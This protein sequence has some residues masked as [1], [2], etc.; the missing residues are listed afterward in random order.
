M[1][2]ALTNSAALPHSE[3]SRF[4]EGFVLCCSLVL[5]VGLAAAFFV[6]H[7]YVLYYGDAQSHLNISRSI[8]D[9]RTP[10]FQ[11]IGNVWLPLLHLICLPF[12]GSD[13][14]WSTGLAGT[15]PVAC[16]F[17][18]TGFCLYWTARRVYHDRRAAAVVVSCF[19]L[20]PNILY[21]SS[22][23]MTEMVFFAGLTLFLLSFVQ[24]RI[25]NQARW[26]FTAI[27]ASWIMSLTRYDGWFLIPFCALWFAIAAHRRRLL[28][29]L[30]VA[31]AASLAPLFWI[32]FNWFETGNALD[33]FNGPYSAKA[34]QGNRPYPGL[35]DWP[36]ALLYY[37]KAGQ[38]CA[39]SAL[40][41][42]GL[43]GAFFTAR[44]KVIAVSLFLCLIPAFYLWSMH[45]SGNPIFVPQFYPYGYYNTRYG[46]AVVLLLA[47][48]SGALA[49]AIPPHWRRFAAIVPLLAII[50][51]LFPLSSSS[52][53]CW[54][55]SER[56]SVERRSWTGHAAAFLIAHYTS[57]E[58]ILTDLGDVTG[59]YCKA[60]LPLR[61]TLSV[62]NSSAWMV[63]SVRPD[64]FHP[65]AWA[66]A[67]NGSALSRVLSH[68]VRSGYQLT[69]IVKTPKAPDLEIYRRLP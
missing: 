49:I 46:L 22:I 2:S 8:I 4:R 30:A 55:E 47:F 31:A 15:I 19:A 27:G 61:D 24:F 28:V 26:F 29:F 65:Q 20:N 53:I 10:G 1:I 59:I 45:S 62:N 37:S 38:L 57:S 5:V 13:K 64:L 56:N 14:L 51:W 48:T 44:S 21:L 7:G 17:V 18:L 35:L 16:C 69:Y 6:H 9:S 66:I 32:G 63:G 12:V 11:E 52:W 54:K 58:G 68:G 36:T 23:P 43:V 50:P 60:E 34:I 3:P 42:L 67:Q 33:F 40:C 41:T 39:G 25:A